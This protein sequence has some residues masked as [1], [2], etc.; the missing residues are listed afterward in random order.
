MH[1]MIQTI[2]II[3]LLTLSAVVVSATSYD[4]QILYHEDYAD[5]IWVMNPD[6]SG[7]TR[8]SEHGWFVDISSDCNK[9]AYTNNYNNDI[10]VMDGDGSNKKRLTRD[11]GEPT[12]S[13][14]MKSIAY[15]FDERGDFTDT[16]WVMDA[17]GR[18]RREIA[19]V[20]GSYPDWSPDGEWILYHGEDDSGIWVI[21]QDGSNNTLL[22]DGGGYPAWSHDGKKIAYV[23][24]DDQC[25]Y[26]M[27][28]DGSDKKKVSETKGIHPAWSCGGE[29]IAFEDLD[30]G[31]GIWVVNADGTDEIMISEVGHSPEY[32]CCPS[33][34]TPTP[35]P[36]PENK[37]S[38]DCVCVTPEDALRLGLVQCG[39]NNTSCGVNDDSVEMFCYGRPIEPEECQEDCVCLTPNEAEELGL[40]LCGDNKTICGVDENG[41][42]MFCYS[43]TTLNEPLNC[44]DNCECLTPE[45]AAEKGYVL[46]NM[47][48]IECGKSNDGEVKY[49]FEPGKEAGA[50]GPKDFNITIRPNFTEVAPGNEIE[51]IFLINPINGF[52]DPVELKLHFE[53]PTYNATYELATQY[54]PYEEYRYTV[55]IPGN[56]SGATAIGT[57]T[58]TSGDITRNATTDAKITPGFGAVMTMI[59]VLF[60]AYAMRKKV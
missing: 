34:A 13:S 58:A 31:K 51:Y 55:T 54:P 16:L 29:R 7:K 46:C 11:G 48:L 42:E 38:K 12:W 33:V 10:W 8:L 60:I 52:D 6:G 18:S 20:T 39:D 37:C 56:I 45:E 14:D 43:E 49:C 25:I 53:T 9:V 57:V 15:F 40:E 1:K 3:S 44:S 41:T 26:T 47:H 28:A 59:G 30:R 23:S 5:N 2:M 27:D 24:L 36:E 21:K 4:E 19:D 35:T 22:Y 32:R 50:E 17:N